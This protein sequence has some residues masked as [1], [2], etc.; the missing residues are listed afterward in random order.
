MV[1]CALFDP[2]QE[3][4]M[5]AKWAEHSIAL[6]PPPLKQLQLG[7]AA[8]RQTGRTVCLLCTP[9]SPKLGFERRCFFLKF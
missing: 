9:D 6:S 3:L 2:S 5:V 8:F 4:C 7:N 1:K